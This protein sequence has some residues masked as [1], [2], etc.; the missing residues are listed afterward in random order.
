MQSTTRQHT[1]LADVGFA[2][3]F[4]TCIPV[5]DPLF[6]VVMALID[7]ETSWTF[8]YT[9]SFLGTCGL[10]IPDIMCPHI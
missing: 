8:E 3:A 1:V 7:G 4:H 10:R 5:C 2:M 9:I 6:M